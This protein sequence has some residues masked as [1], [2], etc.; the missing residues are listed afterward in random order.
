M[1]VRKEQSLL[2][3]C[4]FYASTHADKMFYSFN[5]DEFCP[6]L[7]YLFISMPTCSR[8]SQCES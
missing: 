6:A 4:I 5:E 7:A 3:H 1:K 2:R 8:V